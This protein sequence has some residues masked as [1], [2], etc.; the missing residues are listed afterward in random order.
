M[1]TKKFVNG[2]RLSERSSIKEKN[3]ENNVL[4]NWRNRKTLLN[5][6]T[7]EK[8]VEDLYDSEESFKKGISKINEEDKLIYECKV[9]KMDWYRLLKDVFDSYNHHEYV[10]IEVDVSYSFRFFLQYA[11]KQLLEDIEDVDYINRSVVA[12]LLN[13]FGLEVLEISNKSLTQSLHEYKESSELSGSTSEERFT[14]YLIKAFGSVET[15]FKFYENYPELS[16]LIITRMMYFL[17]NSR[18]LIN[19][20]VS[21][22]RDI[23]RFFKTKDISLVKISESKGDSH[24]NGL[25]V[26][27]LGLSNG[28]KLVYKPKRYAE[29]EGKVDDLLR[30]LN[31]E[32]D[33]EVFIPRKII[34]GQYFYEEFIENSSVDSDGDLDDYY[35]RYGKLIGVGYILNATDLHYENVVA[36]K[37][38]PV[39]ID[40]ETFFQQPIPLEFPE[41]AVTDAKFYYLNSIMST[42]LVPYGAFKSRS[43]DGSGIDLSPLNSKQQKVP[44]KVL[45]PTNMN[46]DEMKYEYGD[47]MV[48]IKSNLPKHDDKSYGVTGFEKNVMLGLNDLLSNVM[49]KKIQILN[50]VKGMSRVVVRNVIRPTQKY[51]D[52]LA[53]SYHGKAMSDSIER[54]KVL[55]N[56][57]AY[58]YRDLRPVKYEFYEL[59]NGDIPQFFNLFD[60][61]NLL[62]N[63]G[64]ISDFYPVT[65]K[66][67]VLNKI[68]SL[69]SKDIQEQITYLK[70]ALNVYD[71]YE[72]LSDPNNQSFDDIPFSKIRQFVDEIDL[73]IRE[74]AFVNEKSQTITWM[75]IRMKGDWSIDVLDNNLY[76][77]L[78][79]IYL[80]YS[81]KQS[82]GSSEDIIKMKQQL[83][84]IMYNLPTEVFYT[85]FMGKAS[86][87]YPLVVDYQLNGDKDSLRV[88][89]E[90]AN[91]ILESSLDLKIED[92]WIS[93]ANSLIKVFIGL[94]KE[95]GKQK[96]IDFANKMFRSLPSR[97]YEFVGMAHGKSSRNY[98]EGLL[99]NED[100][101]VFDED[102]YFDSELQNWKKGKLSFESWCKGSLGISM[103]RNHIKHDSVVDVKKRLQ[104][105]ELNDDCLCHGRAG[106]IE[107]LMGFTDE[108]SVDRQIHL[109]SD[110]IHNYEFNGR[111]NVQGSQA[112]QSLGLFTGIAGLG[113]ELIRFLNRKVPNVLLLD[114]VNV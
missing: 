9:Q 43:R 109:I 7:F 82:L 16:R 70:I 86:L 66:E 49:N 75:D 88:A 6:E 110:I 36:F 105:V 87:I 53:F 90:I 91:H 71:R 37:N 20:F 108:E 14:D 24:S 29:S 56:I 33:A 81:A 101:S 42:G 31:K 103:Y 44:F 78:P 45:Q 25:K 68:Q 3:I 98:L 58:Q 80:F 32:I 99:T 26:C 96:Y 1:L 11:R 17:K 21:D 64:K 27:V 30:F 92:D 59:M 12:G 51:S 50:Y 46:S 76:D 102:Q 22:R 93:G 2:L 74:R 61:P 111:F 19:R 94:F 72:C 73:S 89:E 38:Y 28:E 62:T 107:S 85:A 95:T 69:N 112:M 10:D 97:E 13:D 40:T 34:R 48:D 65:A 54:E 8:M 83:K 4:E 106:L 55:H 67:K 104:V 60:S 18:D 79:G 57:W 23:E 52:M 5:T 113:Y 39:L 114:M 35:Y 100:I 15:S 41:S 47:V 84:N 77:G 63:N